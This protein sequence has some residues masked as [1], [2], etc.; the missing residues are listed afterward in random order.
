MINCSEVFGRSYITSYQEFYLAMTIGAECSRRG[1]VLDMSMMSIV[2]P[3]LLSKNDKEYLHYLKSI[4]AV[5]DGVEPAKRIVRNSSEDYE[6]NR[7]VFWFDVDKFTELQGKLFYMEGDAYHWGYKWASDSYGKQY[8]KSITGLSLIGKTIMHLVGHM[9]VNF[10]L[11]DLPAKRLVFHFNRMEA[12]ATYIYLPLYACVCSCENIR[13]LVELDFEEGRRELRD[14]DYFVLYESSRNS[15]LFRLHDWKTKRGAMETHG[16]REGSIVAMYKRARI[17]ANNPAGF[18]KEAFIAKIESL[19]DS[20][21]YVISR[22]TINKTMEE[23]ELDYLEINESYRHLYSDMLD[24]RIPQS[25]E[26]QELYNTGVCEYFYDEEWLMMPLDKSEI[27]NKRITIDGKQVV[28]PMNTVEA[29]YWIMC[30]F[31]FQF[32]KGMYRD[33]YNDG[34]PLL[35]DTVNGTPRLVS[36]S[37]DS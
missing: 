2:D 30:Q 34:N 36:D 10:I 6:E 17:S 12:R 5:Y 31:D 4:G 26:K 3:Q 23:Q 21:N 13:K 25:L 20:P 35:W 9:I 22:L 11:G 19:G 28:M 29:V 14:L 24:F 16:I 1:E 27:T 37:Q 8:L 15:G 33:M 18:I 7:S 32:D